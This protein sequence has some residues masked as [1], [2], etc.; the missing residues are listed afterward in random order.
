MCSFGGRHS[1]F[2]NVS[3]FNLKT[4]DGR[5]WA[6]FTEFSAEKEAAIEGVL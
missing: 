2:S 5:P 6:N 3:N 1:L 4:L